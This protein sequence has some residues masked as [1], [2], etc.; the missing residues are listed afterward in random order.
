MSLQEVTMAVTCLALNL[1]HEARGEGP[2]G[3]LAV[4]DVT[5]NRVAHPDWP[6]DIC[7]VVHQPHQFSWTA[8]PGTVQEPE[9]WDAAKAIATDLLLGDAQSVLDHT[10]LFFH[11]TYVSPEWAAQMQPLG[12]IGNHL[13][14]G[15][16]ERPTASFAA[17]RP[18]P[19]P[20]RL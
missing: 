4:G 3:M 17:V 6:D 9:A 15:L 11:A 16:P 1:Y 18:K 7:S 14:Y 20:E 13:F 12:R 8:A 2:E 19:R 10:A 5:L